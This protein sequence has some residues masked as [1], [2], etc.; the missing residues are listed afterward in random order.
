MK[1]VCRDCGVAK[2]LTEFHRNK[3]EKDGVQ[4]LCKPCRH[5]Y[6][7]EWYS[8][9]GVRE[10]Q[11]LRMAKWRIRNRKRLREQDVKKHKELRLIV[12]QKISGVEKPFCFMCHCDDIR[13]LE[14]NHKNG[15]GTKELKKGR[16]ARRFYLDIKHCRRGINDLN[17]LCRV[18]NNWDYLERKYGSLPYTV[19]WNGGNMNG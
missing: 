11:L 13:L 5:I 15:G 6:F 2:P 18:C 10:Y 9:P 4:P 12:L 3:R 19:I 7:Q 1:K 14:I 8:R 17:V 16:N